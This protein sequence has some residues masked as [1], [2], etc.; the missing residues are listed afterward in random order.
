MTIVLR[1]SAPE[2]ELQAILAR[3]PADRIEA[4]WRVGDRRG[5][6]IESTNG[7]TMLLSENDDM[8]SAV[9]EAVGVLARIVTYAK[10]LSRGGAEVEIDIALPVTGSAPRSVELSRDLLDLICEANMRV[11][12]TGYP[13]SDDP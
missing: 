8:H 1:A 6:R 11:V 13:C 9:N 2:L 3:L 12:V 4:A 10:E 7:F 5:S